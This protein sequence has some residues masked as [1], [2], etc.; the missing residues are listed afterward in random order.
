MSVP[1][2]TSPGRS[3]F[4]PQLSLS[5]D[6]GAGNGPFGFGWSLSL[7][8][9]TRK[10]DKGLPRYHDSDVF[11]L[12]GAEDLV[13][14]LVRQG[15]DWTPRSVDPRT[16]N[17]QTYGIVLFRARVE[18]LFARLERW[19]NVNDQTDVFWRSITKDNI[20]TFYG[21]SSAS[22]I[23]DPEDST[24]IFT[25]LICESYDDR[26]NAILYRYRAENS[27][28]VPPEATHE[29][30]RSDRIRSANRYPDRILYGNRTPLDRTGSA[31]NAEW[32]F[33]AVFDY[34][35][36][37]TTAV[38]TP[39]GGQERVALNDPPPPDWSI[40]LDP[41]ST[42]RAAFEI[43]TYRLCRRVLMLHHIPEELTVA[44]Y[45][46]RSTDFTYEQTPIASFITRIVQ[47]GF[48]RDGDTYIRKSLPAIE[49]ENSRADVDETV[50]SFLLKASR[51]YQ[52]VW[53][54]HS[55]SWS[56][57]IRR[58]VPGSWAGA[59][60][61]GSISATSARFRSSQHPSDRGAAKPDSNQRSRLPL[62]RRC[63]PG[64]QRTRS[65]WTCQPMV[66]WTWWISG[67][68]FRASTSAHPTRDGGPSR[69]SRRCRSS[70]GTT[71]T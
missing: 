67:D 55:A 63:L 43:R 68:R 21:T 71:P 57:S 4:G 28:R 52:Q 60:A 6:S 51:I 8:S 64:W 12:S 26:G 25:W 32:M 30:N 44:N 40:R 23:A 19:T 39:P 47:S 45:L 37:W 49:L 16:R 56:I 2:F 27:E 11:V 7:P 35:E 42:F 17:G 38:A 65:S 62:N 29:R 3:G 22:R 31:A 15:N 66:R 59:A 58:A 54:A 20:A 9:I 1:I 41:F 18:G 14:V 70:S 5:Y 61:A 46:V 24:R 50:T 48:R 13:P 10:T 34:G 69:R 53:T 33:E 36:E